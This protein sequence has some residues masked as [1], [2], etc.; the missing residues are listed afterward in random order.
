MR[1][2][3]A[4]PLGEVEVQTHLVGRFNVANWLAGSAVAV[5]LGIDL[6]AIAR[7]A[8]GLVG[9]PGRM[10]SI[11]EGQPFLVVIDFA[12]TP[13][14]LEGGSDDATGTGARAGA[15]RVWP[16]RRRSQQPSCPGPRRGAGERFLHHHHR[17]SV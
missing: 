12:H 11:D 14:A 17:R 4:T 10:Q 15:C 16:R 8:T 2:V 7:A 9:V 13:R 3:V 5:G 6:G 1:F